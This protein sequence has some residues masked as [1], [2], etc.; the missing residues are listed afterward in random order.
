M[1]LS[2]L[3]K[4]EM[5]PAEISLGTIRD[6]VAQHMHAVKKAMDNE[7]IVSIDFAET[8]T[9]EQGREI[10]PLT[11]GVQKRKRIIKEKE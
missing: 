11:L 6:L 7:D 8:T 3:S 5:R 4:L 10:I 1:N 2:Q 9:D